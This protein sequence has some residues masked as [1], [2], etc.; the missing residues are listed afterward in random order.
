MRAYEELLNQVPQ[1]LQSLDDVSF[2]PTI[3]SR[4][5]A[6]NCLPHIDKFTGDGYTKEEMKMVRETQKIMGDESIKIS[7]TAVRVPVLVGHGESIN[8]ETETKLSVDEARKILST[9]PGIVVMD[10]LSKDNPRHD[11]LERTY[12]VPLDVRRREYRD[13]VLVGRIRQ[14]LTLENGLNLWCVADNLR[15]GAALNVVQIG[16]LLIKRGIIHP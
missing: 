13:L 9:S 4:P 6:F 5:M 2:D 16:E 12:P 14:D 1:A 3:F 8:I 11:S 7:P 10:E 15:K